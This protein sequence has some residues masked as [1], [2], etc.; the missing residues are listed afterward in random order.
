MVEKNKQT[1]KHVLPHTPC[2]PHTAYPCVGHFTHVTLNPQ[3][4]NCVTLLFRE[5]ET[6]VYL[7][8][9]IHSPTSTPHLEQ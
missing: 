2:P 4:I 6:L 8:F 9:W 5:L 7:I 1:N 3:G